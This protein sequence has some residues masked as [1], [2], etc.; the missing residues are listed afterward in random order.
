VIYERRGSRSTVSNPACAVLV[1]DAKT[2]GRCLQA[3]GETFGVGSWESTYRMAL[4]WASHGLP[5][6]YSKSE[7]SLGD[8]GLLSPDLSFT[9]HVAQVP[10]GKQYPSMLFFYAR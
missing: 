9:R 2:T 6:S 3:G 10:R 5:E 1:D 4:L 8:S 7:E